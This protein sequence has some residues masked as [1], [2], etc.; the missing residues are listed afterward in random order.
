LEN[1]A[2]A[3]AD[4]ASAGGIALRDGD[5]I[6]V[7]GLSGLRNEGDV[8]LS[9]EVLYPGR[10][11]LEVRG[12]RVSS[13]ITR[14]GGL[15]PEAHVEGIRL[16]RGAL[17]VGLDLARALREPGSVD[18]L[19]L[20]PGDG[21]EIPQYDATVRIVGAVEF[22]ARTRWVEGMGLGD[23]LDQAG[24]VTQAGDRNHAVV[25]YANQERKRSG[26]FLFFRSDPRIEPGSTISVQTKAESSGSGFSIDQTL[27][28]ILSFATILVAIRTF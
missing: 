21:I 7:R 28:R 13:L 22:E 12:E 4:G 17:P 8:M 5:R 10:Y 11:A 25:T 18:D 16:V 15:T 26:K 2:G 20:F 14:A 1:R 27:T 24:G 23:Y 6:F 9:G 19:L 3:A